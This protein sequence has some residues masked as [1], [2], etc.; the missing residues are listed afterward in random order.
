MVSSVCIL[1][2]VYA[3]AN[4]WSC[5]HCSQG[6]HANSLAACKRVIVELYGSPNLR[7]FS[8]GTHGAYCEHTVKSNNVT[9]QKNV[10]KPGLYNNARISRVPVKNC[11]ISMNSIQTENIS[12]CDRNTIHP[13]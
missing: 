6:N 5:A 1:E 8:N 9:E 11:T 7:H 10:F 4:A 3:V 2:D 12:D 13:S